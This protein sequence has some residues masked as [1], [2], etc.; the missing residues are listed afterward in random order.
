[1]HAQPHEL[2]GQTVKL[3]LLSRDAPT[4]KTGDDFRVE[5]WWD[6]VSGSSWMGANGN[7]ACIKYAIRSGRAHIRADDE[8]VYGKVG[9]FGHLIHASELGAVVVPT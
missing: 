6:R 3:A 9:W 5:D 4:I 2:A 8:V 7:P 1:M